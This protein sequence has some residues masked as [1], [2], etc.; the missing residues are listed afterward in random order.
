[1]RLPNL[2]LTESTEESMAINRIESGAIII[3]GSGMATG[4][5]VRHHLRHRLP[6]ERNHVLFVGYQAQGTLGR[7]LV[8][9]AAWVRLFGQDVSV[10]AQRHTVGGLSAH[11]DQAG[12]LEWYS[13]IEGKPPVVLVHGEDEARHSL[14]QVIRDRCGAEVELA[15]SGLVREVRST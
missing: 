7:R 15:R 13:A 2:H 6:F 5:R 1:L 4:G 11:A 12:L 9:G 10:R 8:D 14:A 3:A